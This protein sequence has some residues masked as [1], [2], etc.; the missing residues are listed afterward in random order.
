MRIVQPAG[1][2]GSL[3]WLQ[4]A[5]NTQPDCLDGTILQSIGSATAIEWRSPLGVDDYA[6]YRDASF[7][8][9][10]GAED[11][12]ERLADFWPRRGPQWDALACTDAGDILLIE[13]KAH[14][15]EMTS[16]GTKATA[17]SRSKID[18]AMQSTATA[19]GASNV[20]AWMGDYYQLANRLAHL[21]FLR[22]NGKKA[23]LVLVGFIGDAGMKGPS[24]AD[25]WTSAFDNADRA[26]GLP[27][28]HAL[29]PYIIHVHPQV[30]SLATPS[31]EQ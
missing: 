18:R 15:P 17:A 9:R 22:E 12:T 21:W 30:A 4:R 27:A 19:L 5:V 16:S 3:K 2:R 25:E 6:E 28:N 20:D 14:V 24:S 7:L 10:V 31:D 29:S 13:A 11:L 8:K 26:L 1:Q 23:W